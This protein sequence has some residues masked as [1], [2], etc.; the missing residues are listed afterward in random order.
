MNNYNGDF[1][2]EYSEMMLNDID[3]NEELYLSEPEPDDDDDDIKISYD[4]IDD[5]Y[6]SDY[7]K[8]EP[9][10]EIQNAPKCMINT[11]ADYDNQLKI[12]TLVEFE[13]LHW[14]VDENPDLPNDVI[15]QIAINI[16]T[17]HLNQSKDYYTKLIKAGLVDEQD[18]LDMY[19]SIYGSLPKEKTS[20][21]LPKTNQI[22]QPRST[23]EIGN[24]YK[25][26]IE[27][28]DNPQTAKIQPNTVSEDFKDE[29]GFFDYEKMIN[30]NV[31]SNVNSNIKDE[32]Y[33]I[34]LDEMDFE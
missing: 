31:S 2:D 23:T 25:V 18:A 29:D 7:M 24:D 5:D 33:D 6:G 26:K 27:I 17:D 9:T 3:Q 1:I 34:N 12:G 30:E 13:H 11:E 21:P 22:Y 15:E 20:I 10:Q 28:E 19:V 4:N 32:T 14:W 8:Q 16:A